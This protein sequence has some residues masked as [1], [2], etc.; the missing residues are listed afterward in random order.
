[1]FRIFSRFLF[2]IPLWWMV[3][4][5]ATPDLPLWAAASWRNDV[6]A[7]KAHL[8]SGTAPDSIDDWTGKT[9]LHYAAEYGNLE[10]AVLLLD[11]G[12]NA[13]HVDDDKATALHH[14]AVGGF[15]DVAKLLL[16]HGADIN[17]KD[18]RAETPM[19]GAVFFGHTNVSD[20]LKEYY[21]ITRYE[22]GNQF[23]LE[24]TALAPGWYGF[25]NKKMRV[26]SRQFQIIASE[27]LIKWRSIKVLDFQAETLAYKDWKTSKYSQRFFRAE[28]YT[29]PPLKSSNGIDLYYEWF[30]AKPIK[31]AIDG[32]AGEWPINSL[33]ANPGFE[34]NGDGQ[35]ARGDYTFG[36]TT[37]AQFVEVADG[38]WEGDKDHRIM[39]GLGWNPDG[40]QLTIVVEDDYHHHTN[41]EATEGDAVKILFTD[42]ERRK[43]LAEFAFALSD[44]FLEDDITYDKAR[45]TDTDASQRAGIVEQIT[46]DAAFNVAIRRIQKTFDPST[47]TT[48]YE[49]WFAPQTFGL[50]KLVTNVSFGLG[51]AVVDSDPDAPG[52][53]GWAGWGPESV[54]F[55]ANP[56]EAAAVILIGDP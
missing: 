20:L 27:D 24:V 37:Y 46:G 45:L 6:A 21:G 33:V 48:V 43:V 2:S 23:L 8:A 12:A 30:Q 13:R 10:I 54:L 49:F 7:V 22:R 4:V 35:R 55:E 15:V 34:A 47:G 39:M 38:K 14:A 53:Q 3:S 19:D 9:P 51:V 44:P 5:Q 31:G 36:D 25:L 28:P 1:M 18:K 41:K 17:V 56:K 52:L 11:A 42:A 40:L 16:H 50:A 26:D 32:M 29:E